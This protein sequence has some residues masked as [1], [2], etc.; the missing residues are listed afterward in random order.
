MNNVEQNQRDTVYQQK[1]WLGW[2]LCY[3][4][5]AA[6]S[7]DSDVADRHGDQPYLACIS[8]WCAPV[9]WRSVRLKDDN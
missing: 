8:P 3:S 4:P 9:D 2:V 7:C 6:D 1:V 5:P